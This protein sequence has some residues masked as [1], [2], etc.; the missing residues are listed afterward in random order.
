MISD[1][2]HPAGVTEP[3]SVNNGSVYYNS[4]TYQNSEWALM[5][6]G[7]AIFL[8]A[9]G[10]RFGTNVNSVSTYGYYWSSTHVNESYAYSVSFCGP[11]VSL[12]NWSERYCGFSVRLVR[13]REDRRVSQRRV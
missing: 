10:A 8:P 12:D 4:N 6:G 11:M 2:G 5:E 1:Y 7:D 3:S 13:D 9:A